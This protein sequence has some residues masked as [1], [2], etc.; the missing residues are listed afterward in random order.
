MLRE[1]QEKEIIKVRIYRNEKVISE[2]VSKGVIFQ[3]I[4]DFF[5]N[6]RN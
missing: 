6:E 1:I 5:K 2:I 4:K 3:T